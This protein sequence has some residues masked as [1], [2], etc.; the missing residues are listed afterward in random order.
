MIVGNSNETC[1]NV[2][3][4][5][6]KGDKDQPQHVHDAKPKRPPSIEIAPNAAVDVVDTDA[7]VA[8][9]SARMDLDLPMISVQVASPMVMSPG[10]EEGGLCSA[11]EKYANAW[12]GNFYIDETDVDGKKSDVTPSYHERQED[13]DDADLSDGDDRPLSPTDYTLEDESDVNQDTYQPMLLD[14]RPPSPSEFSLLTESAEENELHR[15][16]HNAIP[17]D[18]FAIPDP[19][20]SSAEMNMYLAMQYDQFACG[21]HPDSAG[22]T[23]IYH[24]H[25]HTNAVLIFFCFMELICFI[26]RFLNNHSNEFYLFTS[27]IY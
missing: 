9:I 25:M 22:G 21:H 27:D 4:A 11:M 20:P 2:Q 7:E 18:V 8:D 19:S 10:E 15:L 17:D 12:T 6:S 1:N 16:T 23:H 13:A 14:C 5:E 24:I 26:I 3:E